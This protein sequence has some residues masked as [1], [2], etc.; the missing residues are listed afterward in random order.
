MEQATTLLH[1][2]DLRAMKDKGKPREGVINPSH[3]RNKL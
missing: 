1:N 2:Y 3:L